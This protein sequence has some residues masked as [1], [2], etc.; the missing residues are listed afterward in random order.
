LSTA[1]DVEDARHPAPWRR[2][3]SAVSEHPDAFALPGLAV[4]KQRL[5]MN[6]SLIPSLADLDVQRL[7]ARVISVPKLLYGGD[8]R[9][10][11]AH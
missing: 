2:R 6:G 3:K 1:V 7:G 5:E 8:L 11:G 4:K 10:I 9:R